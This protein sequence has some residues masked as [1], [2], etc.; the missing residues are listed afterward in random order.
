M[1]TTMQK[2]E[3]DYQEVFARSVVARL[4]DASEKL[5]H[6]ISERLKAARNLALGKRKLLSTVKV[7][8]G[9]AVGGNT[10]ALHFGDGHRRV[11]NWFAAAVP[12]IVLVGGLF[13]IDAVQDGFGAMEIAEVDAELLTDDLPPAAYTDPGFLG[14]LSVKRQD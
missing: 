5:P 1:N 8:S 4:N 3:N 2:G 14:F 13:A 9:V 6:D 11:W 10:V 12:L 7:A